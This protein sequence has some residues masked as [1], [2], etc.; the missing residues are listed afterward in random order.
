MRIKLIREE[1]FASTFTLSVTPFGSHLP[2]DRFNQSRPE[3]AG[4]KLGRI[5]GIKYGTA[6]KSDRRTR[7]ETFA[8]CR[9]GSSFGAPASVVSW[10]LCQRQQCIQEN[11]YIHWVSCLQPAGE[12]ESFCRLVKNVTMLET[13]QTAFCGRNGANSSLQ[14][15]FETAV[16]ESVVCPL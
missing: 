4:E 13:S 16:R 1:T 14:L 15:H 5:R 12:H 7:F 6:A 8:T 3:P 9:Y 11:G 10:R 2:R